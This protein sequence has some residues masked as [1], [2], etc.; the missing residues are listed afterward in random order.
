MRNQMFIKI[1]D[2]ISEDTYQTLQNVPSN[3]YFY[4]LLGM[5]FPINFNDLYTIRKIS[6]RS[7][8]KMY[9]KR[10][11]FDKSDDE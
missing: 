6:V 5:Q 8:F 1:K 4:I 10:Q 3:I 9:K 7:I 11:D 2:N